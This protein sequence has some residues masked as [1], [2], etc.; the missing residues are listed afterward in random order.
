MWVEDRR[1]VLGKQF[2]GLQIRWCRFGGLGCRF[3]CRSWSWNKSMKKRVKVNGR[4]SRRNNLVVD[5]V[6]RLLRLLL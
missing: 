4:V 3:R 5:V 1:I 6:G 2:V